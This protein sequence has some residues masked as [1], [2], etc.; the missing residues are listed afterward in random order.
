MGT[1]GEKRGGDR[2]NPDNPD[3]PDTPWAAPAAGDALAPAPHRESLL[4]QGGLRKDEMGAIYRDLVALMK[5]PS[6]NGT[7]QLEHLLL[8]SRQEEERRR[9]EEEEKAQREAERCQ[10]PEEASKP[11]WWRVELG[12]GATAGQAEV[13]T[14]YRRLAKLY[15]PDRGGDAKLFT[16]VKEAYDAAKACGVC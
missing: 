1:A 16:R 7:V 2:N 15:H 13:K 8:R 12:V 6:R 11:V 5:R 10:A 14:A 3:N 9:Q 4:R